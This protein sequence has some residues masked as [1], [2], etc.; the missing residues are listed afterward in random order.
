M[1]DTLEEQLNKY[2][3]FAADIRDNFDCDEDAH[4]Y[5]NMCRCCEAGRVLVEDPGATD[6]KWHWPGWSKRRS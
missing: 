5:G 6:E 3:S 2:R 1:A 4:K